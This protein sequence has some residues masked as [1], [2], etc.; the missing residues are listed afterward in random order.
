MWDSTTFLAEQVMMKVVS[1]VC[2]AMC[3]AARD[4]CYLK[5]DSVMGEGK[6][7]D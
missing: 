3:P 2:P 1:G 4:T 6:E 7:R 5:R